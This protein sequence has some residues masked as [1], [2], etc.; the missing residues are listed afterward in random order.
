ML[1]LVG[2]QGI[3]GHLFFLARYAMLETGRRSLCGRG[4]ISKSMECGVFFLSSY[5]A[6]VLFARSE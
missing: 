2:T 5:P 4:N 6:S 3:F 1:G